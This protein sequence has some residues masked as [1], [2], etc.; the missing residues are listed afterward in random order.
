MCWTVIDTMIDRRFD[1]IGAREHPHRLADV[2][3]HPLHMS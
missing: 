3:H 1:D 2:P